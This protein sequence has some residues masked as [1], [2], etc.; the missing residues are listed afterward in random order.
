MA[1]GF[2]APKYESTLGLES[3]AMAGDPGSQT[4]L[5]DLNY[6]HITGLHFCIH[7]IGVHVRRKEERRNI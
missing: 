4:R 7:G 5:H 6:S 2:L 3:I 1:L